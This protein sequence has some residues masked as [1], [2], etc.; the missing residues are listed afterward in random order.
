MKRGLSN[1]LL[2]GLL[3]LLLVGF[4]AGAASAPAAGSSR[5][6]SPQR[7][8]LSNDLIQAFAQDGSTVAWI[9]SLSDLYRVRARNLAT[10]KSVVLGDANN[11]RS[12][13][14]PPTLALAG[15]RA[16]W[17]TCWHGN[18]FY[19]D[20]HTTTFAERSKRP[21]PK[22]VF[23]FEISQDNESGRDGYFAGAA[24]D[25]STLVYGWTQFS[26]IAEP[27][28]FDRVLGGGGVVR[29][30]GPFKTQSPPA[31]APIVNV[32]S[33]APSYSNQGKQ[34]LGR[35]LA[36]SQGRIAVVP[37]QASVSGQY[38]W[39]FPRPAENGP[40]VVSTR[41]GTVISR[42]FP[43]GTVSGIALAWPN[44]AVLVQR[45]DGS[46]TVVLYDAV[47]GSLR[48][49]TVV[50]A[51]ATD[52]AI[53]AGVVYRVGRSIYTVRSGH[54]T[55][56]WRAQVT[57]IGLSIEGRRVTWAVNIKGRGRIF[58]LTLPQ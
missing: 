7:L 9:N 41:G 23:L 24:G 40:V 36:V 48:S 10:G 56:L 43:A 29:V 21:L 32:P 49:T 34:Q 12:T 57:P 46:N 52:L 28:P 3:A 5:L 35:Q 44:L 22:P 14:N 39:G 4:M 51:S 13:L 47:T 20:G 33:P 50:P 38:W 53:G 45:P 1:P 58:A 18:D 31:A 15:G 42:V 25:G 6:T 54:P 16:F 19:I 30:V 37:P 11:Y 17:T 55:L 26:P 2:A 8:V 27:P